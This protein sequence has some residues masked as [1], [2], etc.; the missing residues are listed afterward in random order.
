[1]TSLEGLPSGITY[2]TLSNNESQDLPLLRCLTVQGKV[3]ITDAGDSNFWD[4]TLTDILND[5]RWMGKGKQGML[6]CALE[7]KKAGYTGNA[8]W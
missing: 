5:A 3:A 2:C 1:L 8:K 4:K 7:L 6:N